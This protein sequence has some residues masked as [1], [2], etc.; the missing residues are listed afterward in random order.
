MGFDKD[1]MMVIIILLMKS[2][3]EGGGQKPFLG[4][5]MCWVGLYILFGKVL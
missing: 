5:I 4:F 1:S 3:G 2:E